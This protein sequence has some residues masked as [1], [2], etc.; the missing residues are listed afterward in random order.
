[1][2]YCVTTD[3]SLL[4]DS[5]AASTST[6]TVGPGRTISRHTVVHPVYVRRGLAG[7]ETG[8][9][10]CIA[11]AIALYGCV[12]VMWWELGCNR[13]QWLYVEIFCNGYRC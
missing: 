3:A 6:L 8:T 10:L 1:M 2:W 12:V 13:T 9:M 5:G 7:G 11:P 4:S